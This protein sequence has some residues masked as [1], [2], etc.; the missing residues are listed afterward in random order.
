MSETVGTVHVVDDDPAV[1]QSLS[2]LLESAGLE[3]RTYGSADAFVAEQPVQRP[4][5]VLLDVRLP[6]LGGLE[7]LQR[8][9]QS[10]RALPT[11]IITG[12]AD[13]P[14]AVRAMKIGAMDFVEKPFRDDLLLQRVHAALE[15]DQHDDHKQRAI[16][17]AR[18]RAAELS[19]R[20]RQV[21]NLVVKGLANKQAAV[22]LGISPKTV[23][24]HRGRVMHKMQARSVAELTR[25]AMIAGLVE[26]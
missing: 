13:V 3:V 8:L 5:C 11:I 22:A 14:M 21:M 25:M 1:R 10:G 2:W 17:E 6:G 9:G 7:L 18:R 16:A 24:V 4:A 26:D 15:A 20:E 23:E 19:R 12:H